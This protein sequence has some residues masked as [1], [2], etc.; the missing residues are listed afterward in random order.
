LVLS[1]L[2]VSL[3]LMGFGLFRLLKTERSATP[4]FASAFACLIICLGVYFIGVRLGPPDVPNPVT[5]FV[6]GPK[7]EAVR[8]G[9]DAQLALLPSARRT[10]T[11]PLLGAFALLPED[12]R[13]GGNDAGAAPKSLH[14]QLAMNLAR[15]APGE[16]MMHVT[17]NGGADKAKHANENVALNKRIQSAAQF[18]NPGMMPI[19]PLP[20]ASDKKP[21]MLEG[22]GREYYHQH[23]Q[24]V[25]ADTLLWH[26]NLW[27]PD[28]QGEVHFDIGA[29]NV[30]YRVLLLGHGPN[31]R[32]GFY[33][34]RIDVLGR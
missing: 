3:V 19:S 18:G 10:T 34:T 30:T 11:K 29:G 14:D 6:Q 22:A 13:K 16:G 21:K 4:A 5:N 26:P 8:D 23:V 24:N 12:G 15:Q 33:E 17:M 27:L 31:G 28:G 32:F 1:L 7:G 25:P 20:P 2:G 9:L